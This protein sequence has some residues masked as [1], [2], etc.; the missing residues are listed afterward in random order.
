[1][2]TVTKVTINGFQ[3]ELREVVAGRLAWCVLPENM[4]PDEP[5]ARPKGSS[6]A[7]ATVSA[8]GGPRDPP[9]LEGHHFFCTDAT[10]VYEHFFADF[11]PLNLGTLVKCVTSRR[12]LF[13][14]AAAARAAKLCA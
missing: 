2:A 14:I 13:L 5:I 1:M 3:A 12:I 7:D 10:H 4:C 9:R 8:G 6:P 11:G